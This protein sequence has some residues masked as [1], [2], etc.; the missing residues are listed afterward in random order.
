MRKLLKGKRKWIV[1]GILAAGGAIAFVLYRRKQQAIAQQAQASTMLPSGKP[2]SVSHLL[3][4]TG[5]MNTRVA[6]DMTAEQIRQIQAECKA[7]GKYLSP[8]LILQGK[9]CR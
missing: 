9:T 5:Q 7:K 3:A 6:Q 1:L 8:V 4:T 2:S